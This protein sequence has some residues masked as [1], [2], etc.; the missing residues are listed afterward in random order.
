MAELV[1]IRTALPTVYDRAAN[2]AEFL[3]NVGRAIHSS[4]MFGCQSPSQG[5][6]LALECAARRMPPLALTE[7]YHLILGKLSMKAEAM[8]TDFANAGGTYDL[9]ERTPEKA[10]IKLVWKRKSHVFTLTWEAAQEEPYVYQGKEGDVVAKLVAGKRSELKLKDKYATPGSRMQML[11]AR[12]TSDA[13]RAIAS[14][15]TIGRYTPEEITDFAN[16]E[17][18]PNEP[19]G[20]EAAEADTAAAPQ[21][22]AGDAEQVEIDRLKA[23]AAAGMAAAKATEERLVAETPPEHQ[24]PMPTAAP[25][26]AAPQPAAANGRA[27]PEQVARVKQLVGE[28]AIPRQKLA[29]MIAK[30]N[31]AKVSE[32]SFVNCAALIEAMEKEQVK[33][34]AQAGN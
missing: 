4:G 19:L 29:A 6:V 21:P 12:V 26:P 18:L 22:A 9:I 16:V 2:V 23:E 11:W 24:K 30:G 8:R 17:V 1:P 25:Q 33:R 10:A 34:Q 28:L 32:L 14:E 31:A 20:E 7:R 15:V 3:V 5:Y 13:I 27:T